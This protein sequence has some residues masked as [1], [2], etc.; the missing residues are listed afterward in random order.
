MLYLRDHD[1]M[2]RAAMRLDLSVGHPARQCGI[3]A[4]A[5]PF[6]GLVDSLVPD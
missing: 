4:L 6:V 2:R 5:R 1:G 3:L